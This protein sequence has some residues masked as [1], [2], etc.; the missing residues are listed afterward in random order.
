M[1]IKACMLNRSNMVHLKN[2]NYKYQF[3]IE[4]TV[5]E[6]STLDILNVKN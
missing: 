4:I 1:L 6:H 5:Y 3:L 2:T